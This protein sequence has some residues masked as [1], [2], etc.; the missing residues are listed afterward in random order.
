MLGT[1]GGVEL[2][3][4]DLGIDV[5]MGSGLLAAQRSFSTATAA[6]ARA[7]PALAAVR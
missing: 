4:S 6:A 5:E 2:S 3:F 1:L 7:E